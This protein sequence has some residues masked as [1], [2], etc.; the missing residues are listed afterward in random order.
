MSFILLSPGWIISLAHPIFLSL[1]FQFETIRTACT[2]HIRN[3]VVCWLCKYL[4]KM[5]VSRIDKIEYYLSIGEK[6]KQ[7]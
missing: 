4:N 1:Y 2:V 3:Y 7:F 5:R 6:Q